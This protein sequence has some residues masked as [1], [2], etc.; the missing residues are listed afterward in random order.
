MGATVTRRPGQERIARADAR[1]GRVPPRRAARLPVRRRAARPGRGAAAARG[2][3]AR[4]F[5]VATSVVVGACRARSTGGWTRPSGGRCSTRCSRPGCCSSLQQVRV[6]APVHARRALAG[7]STAGSASAP[8]PRRSGRRGRG[9]RG[10]GDLDA[11]A[12]LVDTRRGNGLHAR[13]GRAPATL[14][15]LASYVQWALAAILVGVVFSWRAALALAAGALRC[16]RDPHGLRSARRSRRRS[17][18]SAGESDYFRAGSRRRGRKEIRIFGLLA[19]LGGRYRDASNA[20]ASM[21][22]WRSRRKTA[23]AR[24]CCAS[25]VWLVAA[26]A[27]DRRR[28]ARGGRGRLVSLG[29]LAFVLQG[30]I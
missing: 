4:A 24:T 9:A 29:E 1:A 11:L 5:I 3:D 16:A 23:T 13:L 22:V 15:L 2:A 6:P 17:R 12:D 21:P 18:R 25:P 20:A 8:L 28:G 27:R 19:W 30:I 26:R 10:A 7:A 14:V